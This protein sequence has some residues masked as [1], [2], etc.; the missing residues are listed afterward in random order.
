MCA[1]HIDDKTPKPRL[2]YEQL[3]RRF[4]RETIARI[5]AEQLLETK[6]R[7]LHRTNLALTKAAKVLEDHRRQLETT[8]DQTLLAILLVRKDGTIHHANKLAIKT[9]R[10]KEDYFAGLNVTELFEEII[11]EKKWVKGDLSKV[12]SLR[13]IAVETTGKRTDGTTFPVEYAVSRTKLK[14]QQVSVWVARN[15]SDRK[16]AEKRRQS[17]EAELRQAQKL[18]SLGTLASGVAHEINTPIQYIS[19]NVQ[20]LKESF[21]DLIKFV[22]TS[23]DVVEALKKADR[24]APEI[25]KFR[26]QFKDLDLDFV[27]E[28][29]PSALSQS[30]HGLQQVATIVKAIKEFS[31]PGSHKMSPVDINRAIRTTLAVSRNQWK[32]ACDVSL[33]LEDNLPTIMGLAGDINQ[34]LLNLIVNAVDAIVEKDPQERGVI[35]LQTQKIHTDELGD[36]VEIRVTD[37]GTGIAPD[38]ASR[39]F[40][41][42]FTTKAVGKGT[43]QGLAITYNIICTKH[44]GSIDCQSPPGEG[45]TFIMR[46]PCQHERSEKEV[47]E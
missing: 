28:E 41:P 10:L 8:L 20:F 19:D 32:Y 17:L 22:K 24:K 36:A 12:E 9:F 27:L 35:T 44:G 16:D 38:V 6:S 47:R 13:E 25:Q 43:G 14:G 33:L 18:E 5:E 37:T 45:A 30:L 11:P 42:F 2:S 40:D 4:E 1:F 31:H 34:V 3:L 15:I 29:A 26:E 46:L 7:E 21:E 23:Q 39:M